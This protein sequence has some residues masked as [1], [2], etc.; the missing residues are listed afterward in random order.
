[1]EPKPLDRERVEA[2]TQF[3]NANCDRL[4]D[5]VRELLHD[6]NGDPLPFVLLLPAADGTH[7]CANLPFDTV[8]GIVRACADEMRAEI[9]QKAFARALR[10]GMAR[11]LVNARLIGEEDAPTADDTN[12]TV[13]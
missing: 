5:A 1:M 13:N 11:V 8:E 12:K 3:V 9:M 4:H 2:I 7:T 10:E 6:A